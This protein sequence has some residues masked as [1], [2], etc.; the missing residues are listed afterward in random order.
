[1]I[2]DEFITLEYK[3]DRSPAILR[4]EYIKGI[5]AID[6]KTSKITYGK[7]RLVEVEVIGKAS[8]LRAMLYANNQ[9]DY[10]NGKIS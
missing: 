5:E 2:K 8:K 6:S 1:M 9:E 4:K 3:D 7:N 10:E